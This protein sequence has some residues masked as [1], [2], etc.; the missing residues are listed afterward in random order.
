MAIDEIT[1]DDLFKTVADAGH[2]AQGMD[3]WAYTD[4]SLLPASAFHY[5]VLLLPL[6]QSGK[7]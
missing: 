6:N 5:L 7:P 3:H 1:G 4:L 2:T